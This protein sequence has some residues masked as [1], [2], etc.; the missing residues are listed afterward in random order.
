MVRRVRSAL[1]TVFEKPRFVAGAVGPTNRTASI[2]PKVSDPGYRN[3]NFDELCDAYKEQVRGLI[4]VI[5]ERPADNRNRTT[6]ETIGLR[7]SGAMCSSNLVKE[8]LIPA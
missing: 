5:V 3:V 6:P 1:P 7:P 2:S 4:D 8:P